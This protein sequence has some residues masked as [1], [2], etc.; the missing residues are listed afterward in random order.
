MDATVFVKN[1]GFSF[2]EG[3]LQDSPGGIAFEADGPFDVDH[4]LPGHLG[5]LRKRRQCPPHLSGGTR[6][7]QRAGD[8]AVGGHGAGGHT[9]HQGCNPSIPADFEVGQRHHPRPATWRAVTVPLS[10]G[11]LLPS[12]LLIACHLQPDVSGADGLVGVV[13]DSDGRPVAGL[14]VSSLETESITA[15]D[16]RFAVWFKAPDQFVSFQWQ[17]LAFQRAFDPRDEGVVVSV[18]LP[19][20][21]DR[22]VDCGRVRADVALMWDFGGGLVARL[23]IRCGDGGSARQVAPPGVPGVEKGP[24]GDVTVRATPAGLTLEL[25]AL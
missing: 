21:S 23:P 15:S 12:F 24:M 1:D 22:E 11:R 25:G 16:G 20:L 14:R 10:R 18:A 19:S 3:P 9:R 7:A 5:S 6:C 2:Q 17:G 13:S 4:P 8:V